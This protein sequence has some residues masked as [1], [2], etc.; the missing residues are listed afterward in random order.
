M[1]PG[2]SV[3]RG[4]R[5]SAA[6]HSALWGKPGLSAL[7]RVRVELSLR[8]RTRLSENVGVKIKET[9]TA[10]SQTYTSVVCNFLLLGLDVCST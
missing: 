9:V 7:M 2:R 3:L 4:T 6:V 5:A 1:G 10:G 8:I